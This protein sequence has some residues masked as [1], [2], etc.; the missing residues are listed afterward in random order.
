MKRVNAKRFISRDPEQRV[1][2]EICKN[3]EGTGFTSQLNCR[4]SGG[5]R[6][7]ERRRFSAISRQIYANF[8][9][10]NVSFCSQVQPR[11]WHPRVVMDST[12]IYVAQ[13]SWSS[14]RQGWNF[15]IRVAPGWTVP[16]QEVPRPTSIGRPRTDIRWT[17]YRECGGCWGTARWSF[18]RFRLPRSGRMCTARPT[19]AWRAIPSVECSAVTCRSGQV[20][21][22]LV[23]GMMVLR[24]SLFSGTKRQFNPSQ[25]YFTILESIFYVCQ[26]LFC[27]VRLLSTS[28][29]ISD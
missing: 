1:V 6:F 9:A 27:F 20:R 19:D 5:Q 24:V 2:R 13:A 7:S 17:T 16:R 29:Y 8:R 15:R 18:C 26:E 11:R 4:V 10:L 3:G 23:M 28:K 12:H 22:L 21:K 25:S 14:H